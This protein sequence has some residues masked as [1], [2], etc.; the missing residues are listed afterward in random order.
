MPKFTCRSPSPASMFTSPA[1][2][3]VTRG[4]SEQANNVARRKCKNA[5]TP[6]H[7]TT[8]ETITL[9]SGCK[10]A[11]LDCQN[12]TKRG[13]KRRVLTC[14]PLTINL[15]SGPLCHPRRTQC[16]LC[17]PRRLEKEREG[18]ESSDESPSP[19]VLFA[20]SVRGQNS[21]ISESLSFQTG[22]RGD[23]SSHVLG[24]SF[25][26]L[27]T[28]V[29]GQHFTEWTLNHVCSMRILLSSFIRKQEN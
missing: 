11:P 28:S 10:S 14:I 16:A 21:V 5:D 29:V 25:A 9:S 23:V 27:C 7:R 6:F 3:H 8:S 26:M 17:G 15:T 4:S 22:G 13:F 20:S 24:L 2:D 19:L 12:A 18:K 1:A